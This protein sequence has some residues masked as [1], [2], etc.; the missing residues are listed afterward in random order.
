[1]IVRHQGG[2][3]ALL[4]MEAVLVMHRTA[5]RPTIRRHCPPVACDVGTRRALYDSEQV[6]E[7][8]AKVEPRPGRVGK[9][10]VRSSRSA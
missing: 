9:T 5:T 3:R 2:G 1:M 8:L 7:V 6:V 10:L 4:D